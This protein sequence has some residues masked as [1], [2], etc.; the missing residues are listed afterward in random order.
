[1][2]LINNTLCASVT[3]VSPWFSFLKGFR[4][5]LNRVGVTEKVAPTVFLPPN[6]RFFVCFQVINQQ[7][8]LFHFAAIEPE[9]VVWFY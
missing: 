7:H 9:R 1:M 3:S 5:V 4:I 8:L 2:V 6:L